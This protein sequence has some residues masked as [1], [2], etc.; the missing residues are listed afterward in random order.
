MKLFNIFN[1]YF[2][3]LIMKSSLLTIALSIAKYILYDRSIANM[4]LVG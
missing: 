2:E 4:M 3:F 1:W